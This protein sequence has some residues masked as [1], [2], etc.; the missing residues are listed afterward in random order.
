MFRSV[1]TLQQ[2]KVPIRLIKTRKR[3]LKMRYFSEERSLYQGIFCRGEHTGKE[4]DDETGLYYYGARYLDPKYSRW[5]STD[6][7]LGDYIPGAPINDE[8][9][10][11]NGELPG[12]GGVFNTV[13]LHLYHYAGN[14]PV[15]YTDPD[16]M[17]ILPTKNVNGNG[18]VQQDSK[19]PLGYGPSTVS[20]SGCYITANARVINAIN[21]LASRR[22]PELVGLPATDMDILTY[23]KQNFIEGTDDITSQ[24]AGNMINQF[25]A[26]E[27]TT[28]RVEGANNISSALKQYS[29]SNT[30]NAAIVGRIS[31]GEG[32]HFLNIEGIKV[33]ENGNI[34]V[35]VY[36][37]SSRNRTVLDVSEF[38]AIDVTTWEAF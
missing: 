8:V 5:L 14:N 16:G 10:K 25:T 33:D 24:T 9:K 18:F 29:E 4:Q 23:Q 2:R 37:T 11:K 30:D 20:K 34:K 12:M 7:A 22:H 13:N 36:D 26:Y 32:S 3:P 28:T 35:N 6:P 38:T 27:T 19:A 1:S 15:K 21:S 31:L 17:Y